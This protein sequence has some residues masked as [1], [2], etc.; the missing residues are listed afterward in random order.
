MNNPDKKKVPIYF[1]YLTISKQM[2]SQDNSKYDI[3][4]IKE[5]FSNFLEYVLD[6]ELTVRKKNIINSDRHLDRNLFLMNVQILRKKYSM[7]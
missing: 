1:Y 6:K 4:Q 3:E 7:K 5:S 2:E